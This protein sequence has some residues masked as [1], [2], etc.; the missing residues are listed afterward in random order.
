MRQITNLGFQQG[1]GD[2]VGEPRKVASAQPLG[3]AFEVYGLAYPSVR[4]GFRLKSCHMGH[5]ADKG[6]DVV[7]GL[8]ADPRVSEGLG[9]S[10]EIGDDRASVAFE[11]V[12]FLK[13]EIAE[14][15]KSGNEMAIIIADLRADLKIRGK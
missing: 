13:A 11:T 14:L 8:R 12:S 3:H 15:E 10:V 7:G 5:Q 6:D 4:N 1:T 9:E 2:L